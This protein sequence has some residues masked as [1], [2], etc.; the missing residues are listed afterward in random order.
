M[1]FQQIVFVTAGFFGDP[2]GHTYEPELQKCL[3]D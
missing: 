2:E 3:I 1:P